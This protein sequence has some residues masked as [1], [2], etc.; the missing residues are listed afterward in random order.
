MYC[1][2]CGNPLPEKS[3]YCNRCGVRIGTVNM[4]SQNPNPKNYEKDTSFHNSSEYVR[5]LNSQ[6]KKKYAVGMVML[7]PSLFLNLVIGPLFHP[8]YFVT[9][10]ALIVSVVFNVR[11]L[12]I[13]SELKK[14]YLD[15]INR[16]YRQPYN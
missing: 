8:V 4:Y 5:E 1:S 12:A 2:N 3:Q 9:I 11:A 14:L 15:Y 6:L 10:P 13:S 16:N 7:F